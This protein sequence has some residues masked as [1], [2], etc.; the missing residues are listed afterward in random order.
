MPGGDAGPPGAGVGD[1]V[2]AP[3]RYA[4]HAD[5]ECDGYVRRSEYVPSF[6]GTRLAVDLYLPAHNGA[7][8]PGRFPALFLPTLRRAY[9][10]EHGQCTLCPGSCP[11]GRA[12]EPAG[13]RSK[14]L[15]LRGRGRGRA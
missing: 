6:D 9:Y 5:K 2:S 8:A 10:D 4:G 11:Q 12:D 15:W 13:R 14:R 1:R 7:A 3:G